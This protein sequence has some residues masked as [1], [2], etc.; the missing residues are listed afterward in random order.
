MRRK[1]FPVV[2]LC[3]SASL[4][5]GCNNSTKD[6][7]SKD[8]NQNNSQNN[9]VNDTGLSGEEL[10]KL[11][12]AN[13]RLDTT[14]IK[15]GSGLLNAK[16]ACNYI[17]SSEFISCLKVPINYSQGTCTVNGNT[18]EWSNF[19]DYCNI[20]SYF[21]SY[22]EGI[23]STVEVA[24]NMI[25][26]IKSDANV[27]DKWIQYNESDPTRYML[28]VD[29]TSETLIEDA[30]VYVRI[31]KRYTNDAAQNVYEIYQN[32]ES[33][34][35]AYYFKYIPGV[36]YEYLT[37]IDGVVRSCLIGV[38]NNGNWNKFCID[39]NIDSSNITHIMTG[40]EVSYI[41]NYTLSDAYG[42]SSRLSIASGGLTS[43]ILEISDNRVTLYPNSFSGI[44]CLRLVA[45]T[46]TTDINNIDADILFHADMYTPITDSPS[47]VLTNGE[48]IEPMSYD[49]MGEEEYNALQS[50]VHYVY[51]VVGGTADGYRPALD[52]QVP[53]NTVTEKLTNLN[54]HLNSIGV[55]CNYNMSTIIN[56]AA[57]GD[58]LLN[59]FLNTYQLNGITINNFTN[60]MAGLH[61]YISIP[62]A[63][64][65]L[66]ASVADYD[67]V[68]IN[69]EGFL[70]NN[71]DFT[72]I[73]NVTPGTV[74]VT[75]DTLNVSGLSFTLNN[76]YLIDEGTS[77]T[78]KLAL[79]K[80]TAEGLYDPCQVLA[81]S[82]ENA[83]F[84]TYESGDTFTLEQNA[85]YSLN[86]YLDEGDYDVV[87]YLATDKDIRVTEFVP[88]TTSDAAGTVYNGSTTSITVNDNQT[89]TA[90]YVFDYN[91]TREIDTTGL[92]YTYQDIY[93]AFIC[94]ISE[95][96][97]ASGI[98][99]QLNEDGTYSE[100][101][102]GDA[103]NNCT[104]RMAYT[105]DDND[106]E[107]T[108]YCT[109]ILAGT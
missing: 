28:L 71:Y 49:N 93:D 23:N 65:E 91:I 48:V 90:S 106:A 5:F 10:A 63:K 32:E 1:L 53:G 34:P 26:I 58:A 19:T 66:I 85:G 36:S 50:S 12:L 55:T 70:A 56:N 40:Q 101:N 72:S 99:E 96:G 64:Q 31:C 9:L 27:T 3:L 103:P 67:M 89:M 51:G 8:N 98:V 86:V 60:A 88:I 78:I 29:G 73:E 75:G 107:A 18:Y 87:G 35:Y 4:L 52:F 15:G 81:L 94:L 13:E 77:Y 69:K 47:I 104:L 2:A 38:N 11:L 42:S 41:F 62:T 92:T 100:Y 20:D 37:I 21:D 44:K 84:T 54:N 74:D 68:L 45:D 97:T 22:E 79:A 6:S 17:F 43:D 33:N 25:D 82:S 16:S 7:S 105:Y 24:C 83:V 109:I 80:K 57:T 46:L 14:T 95:Y 108:A 59:Q 30:D 39:D 102:L 61:A 76:L